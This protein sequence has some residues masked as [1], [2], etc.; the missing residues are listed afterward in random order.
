MKKVARKSVKA[1]KSSAKPAHA[2]AKSKPAKA[3]K[4]APKK[5]AA[6]KPK[7][8]DAKK[9]DGAVRAAD[10]H[11][12]NRPIVE[13]M[14]PTRMPALIKIGKRHRQDYGDIEALALDFNERGLLQPPVIDRENNLIAGERR[15]LAWQHP[16]CIFRDK[17]IPVHVVPLKDIVAGEWAENNPD[18]RKN[19]TPSEAVAIKRAIE[20]QLKPAAKAKQSAE[21]RKR[22][23]KNKQ[24]ETDR[25]AGKAAAFTGKSRRTIEKMEAV[26]AAAEAE[27]EKYGRLKDDMDRTGRADGPFKRLQNMK[28]S[29]EIR[30]E[31]APLPDRGPYRGVVIDFPWAAE[32]EEDDPERLA[33]G[34]YPYPTMSVTECVAF[35]RD[36][37]VPRL[38][39]DAVIALHIPNFHLAKGHQVTIVDALGAQAGTILTGRKDRIGRGQIARGSTEQVVIL[40]RG[41]PT[42]ETFPR[43]DFD[44]TVDRKN[45]S[46]KPDNFFRMFE[47]AVAAP[48]Y[49]S[50]F[51]TTE[52]GENWDCHGNKMAEAGSPAASPSESLVEAEIGDEFSDDQL[53]QQLIGLET[54]QRDGVITKALAGLR[55][56]LEKRKWIEGK[57][58][59]KLTYAGQIRLGALRARFE[60]EAS[61]GEDVH[62]AL[63]AEFPDGLKG[64]VVNNWVD[65]SGGV[66]GVSVKTCKCGKEFRASRDL[67]MSGHD[68]LDKQLLEHWRAEAVAAPQHAEAAE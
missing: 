21:A 48:R 4:S 18:L 2:S 43:T 24:K 45:H 16:K 30:K 39:D 61:A 34:Y 47:K 27:P 64:H 38:H 15:L 14:H 33:R 37:I 44:W 51:E 52:R 41:K 11:Q 56:V 36:H 59:P 13:L 31:P 55:A 12:G 5:S 1:G 35:A 46:R 58:K 67:P 17:A 60:R 28:A 7:R 50:F 6:A 63:A 10:W 68:E 26:V 3:S 66:P 57:H 19:F 53:R 20:A 22:G 9:P 40:R 25:A 23:G 65:W 62:V 42:I 29:A 49:A 32:P 54:V 8:A